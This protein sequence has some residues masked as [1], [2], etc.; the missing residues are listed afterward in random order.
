MSKKDVISFLL[1]DHSRYFIKLYS[2]LSVLNVRTMT[3]IVILN[4]VWNKCDTER[5]N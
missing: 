3:I 2:V 4:C 1:V 5:F